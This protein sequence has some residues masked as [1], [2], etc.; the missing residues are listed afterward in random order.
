MNPA[1]KIVG[2]ISQ[3]REGDLMKRDERKT[4][5]KIVAAIGIGIILWVYLYT[6]PVSAKKAVLTDDSTVG[7]Y[8]IDQTDE[9]P[10]KGQIREDSGMPCEN[11]E[12]FERWLET[13]EQTASEEVEVSEWE[14][15]S[16]E[17][18]VNE[19]RCEVSEEETETVQETVPHT[20]K[21]FSVN[22]ETLNPDLQSYLY[23]RLAD[24]HIEWFMPYAI[25]MAYQESH[26]DCTAVNQSNLRDMGLFQFRINYYPGQDI[27]NPY[28]QIDIFVQQMAN[29]ASAGRTVSEMISAHNVSDY[30][31]YNQAYVDQVLSHSNNLREVK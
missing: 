3:Q 9:T 12:Q 27:F 30:G 29:R 4:L 23:Q 19:T 22:G 2:E 31:G 5:C 16:S 6:L 13:Y 14:E 11:R 17:V 15:S 20:A 10:K 26:F 25:M 1:W 28:E 18:P 21:V 24:H 7:E 8:F